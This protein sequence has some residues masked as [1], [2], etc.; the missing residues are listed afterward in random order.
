MTT[1]NSE[2]KRSLAEKLKHPTANMII[3]FLLTSVLA[4]VSL[5]TIRQN[6]NKKNNTKKWLRAIKQP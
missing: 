4:Q 1:N 5:T 3:G 2:E 6:G